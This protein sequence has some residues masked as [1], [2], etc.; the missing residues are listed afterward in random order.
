MVFELKVP[1]TVLTDEANGNTQDEY[2]TLLGAEVLATIDT[3]ASRSSGGTFVA[4]AEPDDLIELTWQG[5]IVQLMRADSLEDQ[6]PT[7]VRGSDDGFI[8]PTSRTLSSQQRDAQSIIL[9]GFKHIRP[10]LAQKAVNT[11]AGLT[12]PP[13]IKQLETQRI[14][15]PGVYHLDAMGQVLTDKP[16]LDLRA[17][18]ENPYLVLIHGTFSTTHGSFGDLTASQDWNELRK[19][20]GDRIVA[21]EHHTVSENPAHNAYQIASAFQGEATIDLLSHSRGGLVGDLLCRYPFEE[22]D[23]DQFFSNVQYQDVRASLYQLHQQLSDHPLN[24]RRF[25]RVAAPVAGTLLASERLD[26]YLNVILTLLGHIPIP[27]ASLLKF[28]RDIAGAILHTRTQADQLPGI[29]AM[30]PHTQHGFVPFLNCCLQDPTGKDL[31]VIAGD[32]QGGGFYDRVK[33]FFSDLYYQEANDFV[34][35]SRSMF[36]GVPRAEARGFYHRAPRAD[37]FSYF[38][39]DKTRS[40]IVEWLAEGNAERFELLNASVPYGGLNQTTQR[41]IPAQITVEDIPTDQKPVVFLLPGIMGTHL[42]HDGKRT[43]LNISRLAWGGLKTLVIEA[44]NVTP[45]GLVEMAYE[46]LYKRLK[47]EYHVIPF[48]FDW[49]LPIQSSAEQLASNIREVFEANPSRSIRIIA[50]S[51]GGLVA[52]TAIANNTDLWQKIK[53][54]GGRLVMLGTPNFGSY[55]PAQVF[56]Q[57]HQLMSYVALV[58]LR[59]SLKDL[60][61]VVRAYPGL[62]EM[63]PSKFSDRDFFQ[64]A[65]WDGL[66]KYSPKA[67]V[68]SSA[69]EF[70]TWLDKNAIDPEAMIY[71]AGQAKETPAELKEV[72]GEAKFYYTKRGDGTVPWDLGILQGVDIYYVDAEHG[73]IPSHRPSFDGFLELLKTGKTS[74]L[75]ATAPV[76][77]RSGSEEL[78]ESATEAETAALRY[79]PS[80][81]DVIGA[82]ARTWSGSVDQQAPISLSVVN[83]DIRDA[84]HPVIVGHYQGDPIVNVEAILDRQCDDQLSRDF[85]FRRYPGEVGTARIYQSNGQSGV[86]VTGLGEPGHLTRTELE[87]ALRAVLLEYVLQNMPQPED[88][89]VSLT[90]CSVLVGSY[91]GGRITIEDSITALGD[92]ALEVNQEL[93]TQTL[94][95]RVR[96]SALEIF[97]VYRDVAIEAAHASQR[98]Q[99]R[100]PGQ[101]L[102]QP[103]VDHRITARLN[104]PSSPYSS[105]WNRR[106]RI[107]AKTDGIDYEVT[108]DLARTEPLFR[109]VQ[110]N[111]V[112]R[113]LDDSTAGRVDIITTLFQYLLPYNFINETSNLP[114]LVLDLNPDSAKIPWELLETNDKDQ[115][116]REP[117]GVRI[118]ILRTLSTVT[119]REN[120]RRSMERRALVIGEPAKVEPPLPGALAEAKSVANLLEMRQLTVTSVLN[121]GPRDILNAMYAADYDIVHIAAHGDFT[122]ITKTETIETK[123]TQNHAADKKSSI[124]TSGKHGVVLGDGL[125]LR[126]D[127]FANLRAVPSIVFLNCCHLGKIGGELGETR[128]RRPGNFSASL[129]EHLIEMGVGVVIAAGWAVSDEPAKIFANSLYTQLLDGEDLARAVRTARFETYKVC[130]SNDVTWGAFQVYG[131]PG[132]VLHWAGRRSGGRDAVTPNFV[133]PIEFREYILN[134]AASGRGAGEK[135][136]QQLCETLHKLQQSMLPEWESLGEIWGAFGDAYFALGA[137]KEA[138]EPYRQAISTSG[139]NL[140]T[141]EKLASVESHVGEHLFQEGKLDESKTHFDVSCQ[142]LESLI[143]LAE[144]AERHALLGA[145]HKRYGFT[146]Q[147]EQQENQF[148]LAQEAYGKAIA[149]NPKNLYYALENK[150]GLDILLGNRVD[151]QDLESVRQSAKTR[152]DNWV[153]TTLVNTDFLEFLASKKAGAKAVEEKARSIAEQYKKVLNQQTSISPQERDSVIHQIRGFA[154]CAKHKSVR[155]AAKQVL[156]TISRE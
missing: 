73:D 75:T 60:T 141:V 34:V 101:I 72:D 43:W 53:K 106:I 92:A 129:A 56:T 18:E 97:E 113:L 104:R 1:G 133:S 127:E 84:K 64:R 77:K 128:L 135:S 103:S 95:K 91:G 61:E 16:A 107:H 79:Y 137:Y 67:N 110:W 20:Y 49:R 134:T 153:A 96:I 71:V 40:R 57:K 68:L 140:Q 102:A 14:P 82:F 144:S 29:E 2:S 7:S 32:V 122:E 51:M 93:E 41:S 52:R 55:A 156:D 125:Y 28:V 63:L 105:G 59:S 89:P 21:L 155:N 30:M 47:D 131:D 74:K 42:A 136:C 39:Q 78:F 114:D 46:P 4:R 130:E 126:S 120:P 117:I 62:V 94:S 147:G 152:T 109:N 119:R 22:S 86:M 66:T 116:N 27:G 146:C 81:S 143:A 26:Q 85:R 83:A 150:I 50:H 37:H 108:T 13:I 24:V 8:V 11:V 6:F 142:R 111:L 9:E 31:A 124:S 38:S 70:R 19:A 154:E 58:D 98:L 25:A 35:D 23:I 118:S 100:R 5:G 69:R 138:L 112:D 76:T 10:K 87:A 54:Q 88:A 121:A 48:G 123:T 15:K 151:S 65:G 99:S 115:K 149:L 45:N 44:P 90:V 33:A 36:R 132:F 139:A 17:T 12:V 148:K 3:R 80:T 145:T